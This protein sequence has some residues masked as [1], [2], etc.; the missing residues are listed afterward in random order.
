MNVG[1]GA[2]CM[3]APAVP[4]TAR[5]AR[6]FVTATLVATDHHS[7]IED[8]RIC[9]SDTVANVVR[10]A[11]V[12]ELTVEVV[13]SEGHV[14]VSVR[15]DDARR[16]PWPRQP[17]REEEAGRGLMLVHRLSVASDVD[18]VWDELELVGKKVWFEL[19]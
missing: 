2:Y 3:T 7:L 19:A 15:D 8:A 6:E 13:V 4:T 14:R 11:R 17:G 16:L 1:A 5:L 9:V 10:H 12:Q 18:W